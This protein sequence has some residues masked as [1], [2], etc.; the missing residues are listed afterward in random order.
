MEDEISE[1]DKQEIRR[2]QKENVKC[3]N[4]DGEILTEFEGGIYGLTAWEITLFKK[5]NRV[6]YVCY[7][8]LPGWSDYGRCKSFYV[9]LRNKLYPDE[10]YDE[11]KGGIGVIREE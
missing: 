6:V 7:E 4:C 8:C 1:E 3:A 10:K 11:T 9:E 2:I 5:D